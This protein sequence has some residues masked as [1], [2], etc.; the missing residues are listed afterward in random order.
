MEVSCHEKN[1]LNAHVSAPQFNVITVCL[2]LILASPCLQSII[3]VD[4]LY[5]CNHWTCLFVSRFLV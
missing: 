2:S 3:F 4:M 5:D 1:K